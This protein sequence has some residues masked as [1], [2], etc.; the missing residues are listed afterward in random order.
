M[1]E[2]GPFEETLAILARVDPLSRPTV[3][4]LLLKMLGPNG[5]FVPDTWEGKGLRWGMEP[6]RRR[7]RRAEGL[8]D[9]S[10]AGSSPG[11]GDLKG[12]CDGDGLDVLN[13]N[14]GMLSKPLLVGPPV[15]NLDGSVPARAR[16]VD[17]RESWLASCG[18]S[19]KPS[20][21]DSG[22]FSR[23]GVELPLVGGPPHGLTGR[24]ARPSCAWISLALDVTSRFSFRKLWRGA[25][26][27]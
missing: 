18:N 27:Q 4:Q 22:I 10:T 8:L 3:F 24:L 16:R 9:G 12:L 6:A 20:V 19:G 11:D 1:G 26:E 15:D 5:E 13:A 2:L 14:E 7:E 23:R 25:G 17:G 21:G